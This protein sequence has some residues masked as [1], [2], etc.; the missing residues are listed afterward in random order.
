MSKGA[1]FIILLLFTVLSLW[2]LYPTWQW[3]ENTPKKE[4]QL[5]AMPEDKFALQNSK[6]KKKIIA[7]KKTRKASLSLGLDLSGGVYMVARVDPVDL[8]NELMEQ[9]DYDE[10][11]VAKIFKDEYKQAADRVLEVLRNRMDSFGV[12]EPSIRKTYD[13]SISIELPGLDNPQQ[14]REALSKVGK[15]EFHMVDEKTMKKLSQMPGLQFSEG[16]LV[17]RDELPSNF[18]IPAD[19]AWYPYYENDQYNIP[20]LKGWYV[21]KKTVEMDGTALENATAEIDQTSGKYQIGFT[22]TAEGTDIFADL[23]KNN[24]NKRMA[25]VLDGKVKSAPNIQS[26]IIGNGRI[27]GSFTTE[28]ANTLA[29]I[30]KSG[31]LPV[32]LVIEEERVIG[33]SLGADSIVSGT[34]A[35]LWGAILVVI[36]MLLYYRT[37]GFIAVIGL[38]FN[39]LF[40]I[41]FLAAMHATLT[42]AGIAGIALTV[43]M[44]VDAN[45]II[46]ERIREEMRRSRSFK[47]ALENG[48]QHAS[49]TIWDSNLTTLFAAFALYMFG[50]GNIKGFGTTLMLG[51]IANIFAALFITRL[52]FDF[53]LDA[54]KLKKIRI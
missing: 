3:Y 29:N 39:I 37:G 20:H 50:S 30:L 2:A 27:T 46:Y 42:L 13:D 17:S 5:I 19:S 44:A 24:I 9:N 34:K 28:E 14:I 22:L 54:F 32:K 41:A 31:S 16:Y 33:P 49:T 43:G 6:I 51:I 38:S 47:H 8:S 40:L 25:I 48:Y 26:Q 23:T 4:Q 11:K 1:R 36:F 18:K 7:L 15:L 45:T 53:F 10:D 52:L 35:F 12:S 21:L